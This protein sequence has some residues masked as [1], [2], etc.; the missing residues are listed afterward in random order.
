MVD[1]GRGDDGGWSWPAW[2]GIVCPVYPFLER[3]GG[4]DKFT[5]KPLEEVKMYF[6]LYFKLTPFWEV[7]FAFTPFKGEK[8]KNGVVGS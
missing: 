5:C 6:L 3:G 7:T 4:G 2:R 1:E 8:I